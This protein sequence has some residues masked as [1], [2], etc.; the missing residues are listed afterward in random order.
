MFLSAVNLGRTHVSG[1]AQRKACPCT[2]IVPSG[3]LLCTLGR[4]ANPPCTLSVQQRSPPCTLVA[5]QPFTVYA[6]RPKRVPTAYTRDAAAVHRVHLSSQT[7][8]YRVHK[9]ARS[10]HGAGPPVPKSAHGGGVVCRVHFPSQTSPYRAHSGA[11]P[12]RRV[13]K[14]PRSTRGLKGLTRGR[15]LTCRHGCSYLVRM[16]RWQSNL[17]LRPR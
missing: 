13:H 9:R 5:R 10:V 12:A 8:S 4:G 3:S 2:L 1:D 6:Y 15:Q 7:G 16:S 11:A 17:W 14:Q